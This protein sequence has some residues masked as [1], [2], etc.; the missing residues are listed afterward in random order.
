MK[1]NLKSIKAMPF[2][3][4]AYFYGLQKTPEGS[5]DAKIKYGYIEAK[6]SSKKGAC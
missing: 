3:Y 1:N 2:G 6:T 4:A 5:P